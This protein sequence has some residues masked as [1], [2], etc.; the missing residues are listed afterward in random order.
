VT[1]D[2]FVKAYQALDGFQGEASIEIWFYS[3]LVR[4]A[5]NYWRWRAV[6]NVWHGTSEEEPADPAVGS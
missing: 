6:R 2:A 5:H 1:Q 3:I 4:Q